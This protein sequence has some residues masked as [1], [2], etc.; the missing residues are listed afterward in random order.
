MEADPSFTPTAERAGGEDSAIE[1]GPRG[2]FWARAGAHTGI[3]TRI[4]ESSS[5]HDLRQCPN[6]VHGRHGKHEKKILLLCFS[7]SVDQTSSSLSK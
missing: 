4:R 6:R 7:V 5:Q 3:L 1:D 2:E